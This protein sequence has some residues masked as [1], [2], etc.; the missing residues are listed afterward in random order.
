MKRGIYVPALAGLASLDETVRVDGP[1]GGEAQPVDTSNRHIHAL[2]D[3]V[4]EEAVDVLQPELRHIYN[5][6][7]LHDIPKPWHRP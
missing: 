3:G 1:A 4:L 5:R 7:G 6:E 2:N